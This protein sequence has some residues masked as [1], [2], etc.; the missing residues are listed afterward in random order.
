L[1]NRNHFHLPPVPGGIVFVRG[2]LVAFIGGCHELHGSASFAR[3]S[4][5]FRLLPAGFRH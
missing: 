5:A 3:V 1:N 2:I 4:V